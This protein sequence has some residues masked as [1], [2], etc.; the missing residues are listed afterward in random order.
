MSVPVVYLACSVVGALFTVNAYR[1]LRN[2]AVSL[3]VFLAG[4]LI[5]ELPLHHLGWQVVATVVFVALGALREPAGVI[6][7]AVTAASWAGLVGLS[8]QASRS[9]TVLEEALSDALGAGY[10]SRMARRLVS[11]GSAVRNW[12]RP[13]PGSFWSCAIPRWRSS[14]TSTTRATASPPTAST[15]TGAARGRR[16]APSWSTCTEAAG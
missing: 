16:A 6:G 12:Q 2:E 11:E 9:E 13:V 4:W 15:C 3:P 1:P 14:A 10:R 8:V 5:S 7:L